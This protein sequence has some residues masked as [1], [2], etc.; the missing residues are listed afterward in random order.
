[1][2][3]AQ[4][5]RH[6]LIIDGLQGRQAIALEAAAYSVGRDLTNAIVLD[7]DTVSRQ[8]AIFLRVPVPGTNQYRYRLVDGNADGKPSTNGTFINGKRCLS[9][10]LHHGDTILFGRKIKAAYLTV[11]MAENE[12][13]SYLESIAFQSIKSQ[14][15]SP[16]ETLVGTEF[17]G[18]QL[19]QE[20]NKRTKNV[21]LQPLVAGRIKNS[22]P[23]SLIGETTGPLAAEKS[24]TDDNSLKATVHED[25]PDPSPKLSWQKIVAAVVVVVA[26]VTGISLYLNSQQSQ[27]G[28]ENPPTQ[29][30]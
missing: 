20:L 15:L 30:Q 28:L 4:E 10:Q 2:N 6:V 14:T 22:E 16:K 7:F 5:E 1:M 21:E 27:P 19:A 13:S 8:H 23:G 17:S 3:H 25:G 9:E 24:T 11:A 26:I 18:E 29:N 12:F